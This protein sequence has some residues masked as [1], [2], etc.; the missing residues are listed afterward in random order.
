MN[1]K[2]RY[3]AFLID[4]KIKDHDGKVFCSYDDAKIFIHDILTEKYADKAIIG[5]FKIDEN[6]REMLI[7]SIETIGFNGDKKNA[8][9]LNLFKA[10]ES[11][12][13]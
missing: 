2:L 13:L 11:T 4:T 6:S 7:T 10:Y 3:I 12:P 9:Q 1:E 8:A 5:V